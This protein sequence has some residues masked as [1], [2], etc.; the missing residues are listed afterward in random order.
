MILKKK[1]KTVTPD[2]RI[3]EATEARIKAALERLKD[4]H[5]T[6]I[7]LVPSSKEGKP[8]YKIVLGTN[9]AVWCECNGFKFRSE[10]RH[11]ERFRREMK[12]VVFK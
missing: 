10:C 7:G 1:V 3:P 4:K 5:T 12:P 9:N 6:V 8:P 2:Q 11:M